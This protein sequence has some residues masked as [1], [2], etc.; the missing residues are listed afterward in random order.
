MSSVAMRFLKKNMICGNVVI[1]KIKWKELNQSL[2]NGE[3]QMIEQ[4]ELDDILQKYHIQ[5]VGNGY[6]DCICPEYSDF[7]N[8][9][10]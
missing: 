10:I 1:I 3:R 9:L 8:R 6:I 5:P 4:H 7:K 2:S